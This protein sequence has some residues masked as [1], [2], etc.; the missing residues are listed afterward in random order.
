MAGEVIIHR[1]VT[2]HGLRAIQNC[3]FA[4][5]LNRR[6]SWTVALPA[7]SASPMPISTAFRPLE[8]TE[9]DAAGSETDSQARTRCLG[10]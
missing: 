8:V 6:R 9:I 5:P 2:G 7:P 10:L 1:D 4:M 3:G